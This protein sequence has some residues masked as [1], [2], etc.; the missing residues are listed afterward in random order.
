MKF[1]NAK[2]SDS[3][4]DR[5]GWLCYRCDRSDVMNRILEENNLTTQH[6]CLAKS[7]KKMSNK[8]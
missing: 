7:E 3:D 1:S 2:A 8:T 4:K 6:S 5:R